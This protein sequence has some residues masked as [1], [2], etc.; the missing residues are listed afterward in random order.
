MS[1]W[2]LVI[3][4]IISSDFLKRSKPNFYYNWED[5]WSLKY[6]LTWSDWMEL[7]LEVT[8]E[9]S[10]VIGIYKESSQGMWQSE[11]K[12]TTLSNIIC[13]ASKLKY[14]KNYSKLSE[15]H[16][17]GF[18]LSKVIPGTKEGQIL[19]H[20]QGSKSTM[21]VAAKYDFDFFFKF[22]PSFPSW[23]TTPQNSYEKSVIW[24][25][26]SCRGGGGCHFVKGWS[27]SQVN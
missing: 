27:S 12:T 22:W 26:C 20:V 16:P 9:L 7:T 17:W 8:S 5:R 24:E 14:D 6:P 10:Q 15:I 18:F 11:N 13:I 1:A 4:N 2:K 23:G 3:I 25:I 19:F 21:R